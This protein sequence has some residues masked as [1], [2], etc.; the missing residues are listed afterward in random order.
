[1][2][3]VIITGATG[4]IG[5]ALV[6]ELLNNK[7]EVWAVVRSESVLSE[8]VNELRSKGVHVIEC[9]LENIR[10]IHYLINEREFDVWYQLAWDGLK[11]KEL[12]DYNKQLDN[13]RY[14]LDTIK[15]AAELQCKK[16]VGSGSIAQFELLYARNKTKDDKHCFYKVA[17][18]A[19]QHMGECVAFQ[20]GID[21]IWPIII[22]VYGIGEKSPRLINTMIRNLQDGRHQSFS[23]G[24]QIYDFV[25][26]TD[27]AKA[28]RLIGEKGKAGGRYIISQG[29]PQQ[30]KH[31]LYT[32]R[33]LIDPNA[34]L[35]LGELEFNGIYLPME[36]FDVSELIEDTGFYPEIDFETGIKLTADWLGLC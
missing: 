10:N 7:V 35:G 12:L 22:N 23:E 15:S 13:V 17:K 18:M 2:E 24:N 6:E 3:K 11:G 29:K 5:N 19:C 25:Y 9:D 4:F 8:R 14:L 27:A 33:D 21:F 28:F 20:C 32:I 31:F 16:F 30:L 36:C 26:I 34:T 1:M